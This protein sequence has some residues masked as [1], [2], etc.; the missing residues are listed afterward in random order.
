MTEQG[1]QAISLSSNQYGRRLFGFIRKRVRNDEDAEDILQDVWFQLS[2]VIDSEP[3]Q[4]I[5][6]WLFRV[7]RNRITDKYRKKKTESL[8]DKVNAEDEE[9]FGA[10]LME[11]A[12]DAQMKMMHDTFWEELFLAL[13][14]LPDKQREVFIKNELEEMSFEEIASQTGENIKTLISRKRYAVQY[15]R[16]RLEELYDE[17]INE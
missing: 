1:Q 13:E 15:L 16:E 5:S 8:P 7:A 6:A 11:D 2:R 4:E 10:L 17:I 9:Y 3:I 12:I 14:E